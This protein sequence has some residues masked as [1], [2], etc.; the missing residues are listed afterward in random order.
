MLTKASFFF[1]MISRIY[2]SLHKKYIHEE[3]LE[4]VEHSLLCKMENSQNISSYAQYEKVTWT[5]CTLLCNILN[6]RWTAA[7][8]S[9][10]MLEWKRK[11]GPWEPTSLPWGE[12]TRREQSWESEEGS[13][14][15]RLTPTTTMCPLPEALDPTI[16]P[17][18]TLLRLSQLL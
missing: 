10:W 6:W 4:T 15:E 3:E 5:I 16:L 17:H 13:V 11:V 14:G 12:P 9:A 8:L 18:W 2:L 7:H 1:Q